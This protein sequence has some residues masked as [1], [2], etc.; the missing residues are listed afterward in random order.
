VMERLPEVRAE[1]RALDLGL[2]AELCRWHETPD[3]EI[4]RLSLELVILK[5]ADAL[6]RCR[7]GDLDPERLRLSRARR[8]VGP[9]ERL[10]RLSR[11]YGSVTAA[12]VL[13]A[14]EELALGRA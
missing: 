13:R 10:E 3:D 6:D 5:D 2:V 12:D 14:A 9:A 8:L 1:T 7:L 4:E 11:N